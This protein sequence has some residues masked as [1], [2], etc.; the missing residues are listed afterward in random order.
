M[1]SVW[2][3][4]GLLLLSLCTGLAT[5]VL[6]VVLG[7]Q[8]VMVALKKRLESVEIGQENLDRRLTTEVKA[9]AGA[10]G[11]EAREDARSLAQVASDRLL[12]EGRPAASGRPSIIS[13]IRR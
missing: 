6:M 9:R 12:E 1:I 10:K 7:V 3:V 11:V 8:G 13:L 2:W 5:A 4:V